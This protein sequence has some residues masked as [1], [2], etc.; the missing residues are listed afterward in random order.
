MTKLLSV[1]VTSSH[2][3]TAV[4]GRP[5]KKK[6]PT[7][8]DITA[9]TVRTQ[10]SN[11]FESKG[12]NYKVKP[13]H[14]FVFD[15]K[16]LNELKAWLVANKYKLNKEHSN[17]LDLIYTLDLSKTK[18]IALD[19]ALSRSKATFNELDVFVYDPSAKDNF[20]LS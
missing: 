3:E 8:N 14:T 18:G 16:A 15:Q 9:K 19:L 5:S 2:E 12:C 1:L 17:K 10:L 20:T 11:L 4:L 13:W 7:T 6:T